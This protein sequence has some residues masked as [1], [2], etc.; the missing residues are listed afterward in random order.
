MRYRTP[1]T[2]IRAGRQAG[3]ASQQF[4][5]WPHRQPAFMAPAAQAGDR[6][7]AAAVHPQDHHNVGH[8]LI[9]SLLRAAFDP[10]SRLARPV[11]VQAIGCQTHRGKNRAYTMILGDS[12]S[13]PRGSK[14][15]PFGDEKQNCLYIP[16]VH[17]VQQTSR[18]TRRILSLGFR[19]QSAK[20]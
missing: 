20:P 6:A 3:F 5:R 7:G 12:P 17:L 16:M 10:S 14:I 9:G 15:R 2:V 11:S 19:D 18:L 8:V 4:L 13:H 1:T